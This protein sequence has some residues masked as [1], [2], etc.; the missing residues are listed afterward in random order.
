MIPCP[1]CNGEVR[2]DG[3]KRT[4]VSSYNDFQYKLYHCNGCHI[5]FWHPLKIIPDFYENEH[6]AAYEEF[7]SGVRELPQWCE[8][9]FEK[10]PLRA[11]RLLDIGCGEGIFLKSAEK[12][13]F[14]VWGIDID[15]KSVEVA[16][17]KFGLNNV[18]HMS[19]DNFLNFAAEKN[20]SFD[21]V[22]FF[23]V[24][25][26]QDSPANFI[27]GVKKILKKGGYIVGSVPNRE[28]LFAD[29]DRKL[30]LADFPP[31][32]FLWFSREVLKR[33]LQQ[34]EFGFF[35]SYPVQLN[36]REL[37]AWIEAVLFGEWSKKVKRKCT[38]IFLQPYIKTGKDLN[39]RIETFENI[40]RKNAGTCFLRFLRALRDIL[41][42]L[43]AALIY[44]QFNRQGLQIYFQS[45]YKPLK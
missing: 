39:R 30:F 22:T 33:Y 35:E 10:F 34:N 37:S 15:R 31:H 42:F 8:P 21:V 23:E 3:C 38:S 32:H 7:H 2:E 4:F 27:E 29:S 36:I 26:H 20:I 12:S 6:C 18:Y 14:E 24:L 28:R 17:N 16:R 1:V 9:F 44:F 43:P 11:G 5:E 19:L 40:Y 45:V 25:E 13:G 41:F